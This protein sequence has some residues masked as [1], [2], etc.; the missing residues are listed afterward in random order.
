MRFVIVSIADEGAEHQRNLA[1]VAH[2]FEVAI[3]IKHNLANWI[4]AIFLWDRL[5]YVT[6]QCQ[7][8]SGTSYQDPL[9]SNVLG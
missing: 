8:H 7:G 1:A 4:N 9:W 5:C 3:P 6:A 2:I